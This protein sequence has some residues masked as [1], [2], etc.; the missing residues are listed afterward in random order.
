M[1][2][3]FQAFSDSNLAGRETARLIKPWVIKTCAD[4]NTLSLHK[5]MLFLPFGSCKESLNPLTVKCCRGECLWT[6]KS[7]SVSVVISSKEVLLSHLWCEITLLFHY[8][9]AGVT[10]FF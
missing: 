3:P 6:D 2:Q 1:N 5:L 9:A 7:M 10:S 8:G 4:R